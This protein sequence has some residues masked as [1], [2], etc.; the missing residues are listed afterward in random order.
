MSGEAD[1]RLPVG[2]RGEQGEQGN[3][4]ERGLS[5]VQGRAVVALFLIGVLIGSVGNLVLDGA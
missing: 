5:R 4:G 1:E 3:R 2:P